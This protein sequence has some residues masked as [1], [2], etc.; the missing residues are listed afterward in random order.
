M[1]IKNKHREK[2]DYK[3]F[4][5]MEAGHLM[6]DA[7]R[8]YDSIGR[9]MLKKRQFSD[10]SKEQQNALNAINPLHPNYIGGK[11][12]I[13]LG[14]AWVMLTPVERRRIMFTYTLTLKET[15]DK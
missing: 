2:N 7:E 1:S 13:L 8:W 6:E 4:G 14:L 11:S 15:T 12:G 3:I 10:D 5:E 9:D